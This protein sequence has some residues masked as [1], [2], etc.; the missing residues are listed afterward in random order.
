MKL[1]ISNQHWMILNILIL[2]DI[3]KIKEK[4]KGFFLKLI[5]DMIKYVMK[6]AG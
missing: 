5:S 1:L 3:R 4:T 6:T 2:Q